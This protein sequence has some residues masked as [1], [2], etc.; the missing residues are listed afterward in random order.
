MAVIDIGKNFK[1]TRK[2]FKAEMMAVSPDSK[3]I[4]VVIASSSDSSV[5]SVSLSS[6]RSIIFQGNLNL[7]SQKL[8]RKFCTLVGFQKTHSL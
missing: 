5:V 6:L 2:P 1:M 3:M 8:L 7:R 4:G